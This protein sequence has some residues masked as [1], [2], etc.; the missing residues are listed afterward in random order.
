MVLDILSR[1][2]GVFEFFIT[3]FLGVIFMLS[4]RETTF[5]VENYFT[6]DLHITDFVLLSTSFW[7]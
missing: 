1:I 5:I 6:D 7:K 2:L 3:F 4:G